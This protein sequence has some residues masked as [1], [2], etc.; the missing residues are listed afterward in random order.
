MAFAADQFAYHPA[1]D[2]QETLFPAT[3]RSCGELGVRSIS[4]S[5]LFANV[6]YVALNPGEGF[7]VLTAVDPTPARPPT[8]RDV[9]L[10]Q[11]LPNDLGH[12]AGVISATPQTPLSHINLKAKQNDTP[13]G[14]VRD[15]AND[16]RIAPLLGQVVR[17]EV[18]AEDFTLAPATPEEVAAWLE[19]V[20]PQAAADAAAR[21]G[22]TQVVDLD[23]LGHGDVQRVGAKAA[24][25]A[26]LRRMLPAGVAPDGYAIPFFFY[27]EFMRCGGFYDDAREIID[28][29][30]RP[31]RSR[32][33]RAGAGQA[34]QED[35]A[36]AT[37]RRRS[38]RRSRSCRPASRREHRSAVAPRRTTRT[39]RASTAPVCMTPTRIAPTRAT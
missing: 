36:G 34:A 27:D 1:G 6:A 14:Y 15:A 16:E 26:E 38:R 5:E 39:S 37:C 7:G 25:V 23:E 3:P 28:D 33:P 10:F 8:I 17:Y 24:N 32:A 35:Q 4:T 30:E 21:P 29:P 11:T 31:G 2:T 12:V 22:A 19:R 18:G 13:N 20:R 9:A